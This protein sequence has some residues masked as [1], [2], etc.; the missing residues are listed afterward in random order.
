MS[1]QQPNSTLIIWSSLEKAVKKRK[2]TTA[3]INAGLKTQT[4][5]PVY[6]GEYNRA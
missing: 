1:D 4:I 6:R 5:Y 2:K 3:G